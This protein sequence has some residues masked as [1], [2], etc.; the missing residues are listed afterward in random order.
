MPSNTTP[1]TVGTWNR[2]D[3]RPRKVDSTRPLRAEV[4]DPLWMLTRQWQLGEFKA[5]DAGSAI[6]ANV[7]LEASPMKYVQK[8]NAS[9]ARKLEEEFPLEMLTE[10]EEVP[11]DLQ[12]RLEMGRH[13]M[14]LLH[15]QLAASS[16][17][18]DQYDTALM[19]AE[20]PAD[21]RLTL[22]EEGIEEAALFS[23][24][25]LRQVLATVQSGSAL[26]GGAL[27]KY[28]TGSSGAKVSDFLSSS[29]TLADAAGV[30]FVEWFERVYQQ[31]AAGEESAWNDSQLE[32]KVATSAPDPNRNNNIMVA[33]EYPGGRLE[34]FHFD[35]DARESEYPGTLHPT[36]PDRSD[37]RQENIAMIP[38]EARYMGMPESRW[39]AFEDGRVNLGMA[40]SNSNETAQLLFGEFSILFSNDWMVL[41]YRIPVGSL[42]T[43]NEIVVTD[44]FGQRIKVEAAGEGMDDDWKRWNF[45]SLN[46]RD[47]TIEEA[48]VRVLVPAAIDRPQEGKPFEVVN[49]VR[50]EMANMVWGIEKTIS[51]GLGGRMDGYESSLKFLT[52]LR[53]TAEAP[54]GSALLS[55]DASIK[56]ELATSVPE[57]WIPFIPKQISGGNRSVQLQRAAMPRFVE[58]LDPTRIEPRTG[59]LSAPAAPYY[60]FEEE[61]PRSGAEVQRHW[62][63]TRWFNGSTFTWVARKKRNGRGEGSS[64]L[65]FDKVSP[66][67]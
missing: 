37:I 38:A 67:D 62:Q 46:Q 61:V 65:A 6:L 52:Y 2:L 3:P 23:N 45:F 53:E 27:Y 17:G 48:D 36:S 41:P 47:A 19:T 35:H 39:W 10:R 7:D 56:Y 43:V 34:W 31:P 40:A 66:K 51:N 28:L 42:A 22:P 21:L 32:Y 24:R 11:M 29:D 13:F 12:L 9:S 63:R 33:D 14:R 59:I 64:G 55:N 18:A 8:G 25:K 50:D 54:E 44:T 16:E 57:N 49:F 5:T 1:P 15:K 26:D 58:G 20:S 4:R 60:L 30:S